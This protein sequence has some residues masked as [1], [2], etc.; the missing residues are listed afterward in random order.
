MNF[1]NKHIR[2]FFAIPLI[3]SIILYLIAANVKSSVLILIALGSLFVGLIF[4]AY[5]TFREILIIYK[6]YIYKTKKEKK[7]INLKK[8]TDPVFYDN[9]KSDQRFKRS[10]YLSDLIKN[11]M[12]FSLSFL[13][14]L[15]V[16][17][18]FISII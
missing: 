18:Q 12:L 1:F 8:K 5:Y 16:I 9:Y 4:Y 6:T 14:V 10:L 15:F 11:I 3:I 7:E 13:C 2:L 17:T